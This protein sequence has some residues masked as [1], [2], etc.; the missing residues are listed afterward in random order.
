MIYEVKACEKFDK[1]ITMTEYEKDVLKSFSAHLNIESVP[2]GVDTEMFKLNGGAVE[3]ADILYLGFFSH[4]PN[5]E[6]VLYFYRD[7]LPAIKK[8]MPRVRFNIIGYD[9]PEEILRLQNN[10]GIKVTGYVEDIRP[11]LA[12]SKV[13][14]MPI[15]LG[16]GMRG[17]LFE[18]WAME[19]AIV[20]TSIG[21]EGI[22]AENGK[23]I[24]IADN[25]VDFAKKVIMLIRD[26]RLRKRLG[27]NGRK[28]AMQKYDW[29]ILTKK[30]ENIYKEAAI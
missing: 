1:I 5:V 19:K 30:L 21:C 26:E 28:K 13:F 3:S 23:D 9:P 10:N 20:S 12:G 17:K 15:R 27:K 4:Y 24:L 2:M 6:A 16:M 29:D 11:Y 25:P 18:A 22:D 7:I 8:E 14:I